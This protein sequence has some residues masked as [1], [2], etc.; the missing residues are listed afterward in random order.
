M[1]CFI[2]YKKMMFTLSTSLNLYF[3]TFT[4]VPELNQYFNFYKIFF[5]THASVLLLKYRSVH[6][7]AIIH[8]VFYFLSVAVSTPVCVC[9][10]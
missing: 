4:L 5:F 3:L 6:T 8:K 2:S 10:C 7:F 9:V 1:H